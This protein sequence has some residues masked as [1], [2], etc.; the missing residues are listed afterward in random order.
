MDNFAT[1]NYSGQTYWLGKN[2]VFVRRAVSEDTKKT[3]SFLVGNLNTTTQNRT[4]CILPQGR[5]YFLVSLIMLVEIFNAY[6]EKPNKY[7][8]LEN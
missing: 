7:S 2:T 1:K 6:F 4:L 8:A 5:V 3:S